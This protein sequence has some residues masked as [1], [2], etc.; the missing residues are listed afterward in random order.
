M[1]DRFPMVSVIWVDGP[2]EL[3]WDRPEL[4]AELTKSFLATASGN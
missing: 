1:P 2:H 4:M 3:D